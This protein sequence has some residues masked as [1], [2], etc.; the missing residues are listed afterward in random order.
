MPNS[1]PLTAYHVRIM[2][3]AK[4]DLAA[5]KHRI[6]AASSDAA[7]RWYFTLKEAMRSLRDN[8]NR[9]PV[10]PEN[11]NLRHLLYGNKPHVYRVIYRVVENRKE[12]DILSVRHGAQRPFTLM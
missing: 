4:R 6:A 12:V 3:R 5:I 11:V 2:P 8:P 7:S 9:C 1:K 10:T